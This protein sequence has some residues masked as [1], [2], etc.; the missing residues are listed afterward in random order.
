VR[1]LRDRARACSFWIASV[2]LLVAV[3]AGAIIPSDRD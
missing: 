1:E 2:I 3:A